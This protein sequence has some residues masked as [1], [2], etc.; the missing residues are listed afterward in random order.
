MLKEHKD[1]SFKP[2][3]N[4]APVVLNQ[5]A[6]AHYN[7][8]GYVAPFRVFNE[9]QVTSNQRYFDRL[10]EHL[11]EQDGYALNCYQARCAGIWDL[12]TTPDILDHIED[13]LGPNVICWASHFFCKM[14]HDTKA[15]P[16]HQDAVYWHLT[17]AKTVT[18]WLAIDDADEEN[19]AMEFIPQSHNQGVLE[20]RKPTGENVA[21]LD[22]EIV[23]A[24]S[25][26]R[27]VS[28][29]LKA[30]EISLHADMLAHGSRPNLSDRR[31]CGL[32]IRYCSPDVGFT[33]ER[34]AQGLESII[35]RGEDVSGRWKHH[36]RPD[37]D[38]VD[39]NNRPGNF[40]G[41]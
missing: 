19:S 10:M 20:W 8:Q 1:L 5:E 27:P 15:V 31:R 33:D 6:I 13:L 28:N 40:G 41:N 2:I 36:S 26:G 4:A 16:W 9:E 30:G 32:T 38:I 23:N 34:W 24:E 22:R 35:C 14:P 11:G 25:L 39:L 3:V 37:T 7:D 18:V 12:C 29:N 21:V 17:P